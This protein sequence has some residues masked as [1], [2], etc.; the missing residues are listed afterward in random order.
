MTSPLRTTLRVLLA[1]VV[2]WLVVTVLAAVLQRSLIY[3]PSGTAPS[4]PPGVEEVTFTTVDALT[5]TAWFVPAAG[6]PVSTVLVAPGNAGHRGMRL[7]LADGLAARGHQVLLLEYRGYGSN[8]GRPSET[9]LVADA[10]AARTYLDARPDVD[11]TR[12]VY[13]GESLGTGVLAALA[14]DAPPL[15]L[16]LRSPFTE[17]ADV[18]RAAY[19]FLPVRTLL[20]DRFP[21]REQLT[22]V[23]V[24]VLVVAG[25]ADRIIPPALSREVAEVS[26]AALT[27]I[28]GADH[29]DRALLDGDRYLDAVDAFIRAAVPSPADPPEQP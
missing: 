7:P 21:T 18:G 28:A 29:N 4:P 26:G 15:A 23:D 1:L 16:V 25:D 22:Q 19:P 13:L 8:P 2:G 12:V 27:L 9:G 20:R 10:Q 17:L 6:V 14:V 5:L 24:P 11:P 3:L